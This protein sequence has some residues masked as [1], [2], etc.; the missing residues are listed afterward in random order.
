MG[1]LMFVRCDNKIKEFFSKI[2]FLGFLIDN[3][4]LWREY[5]DKVYKLF[6]N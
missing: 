5:V 2:I 4:F 3:K 6:G 1:F